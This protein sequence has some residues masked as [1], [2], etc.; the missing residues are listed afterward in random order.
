[1]KVGIIGGGMMGLA[2]AQRLSTRG[3][4]ITVFEREKQLGGLA[5]YHDF[6]QF[7]WDRFYHVI[8]PSDTYLINFMRDI[9][10]GDELR[11]KRTLTGFY[12]DQQFHSVS[13]TVE[14]LKFPLV[15]LV[16]KL[17]LALAILYCAR[18]N[19]WQRLE[20]VP[21]EGWL[22]KTCGRTT[23]EKMWKP[24]LLAKLG[25]NYRRVSAVFIW[26]Y[27]K[28]LYSARDSSASKEQMGHVSGGY[29]A[30]FERLEKSIA[31]AGGTIRT[32][33]S[34]ERIRA[35]AGGGLWVDHDQG[36]DRF[37]KVV[38]TSPVNVLEKV[39]QQGLV[40]LSN[41]G[42]GVEYLGVICMVLVTRKP[43]V[44]YYVVN[45]ADQRLPFT[46][47]IGM[48][49]VV[50]TDETAGFYLTYLPKYVLSD[51]P[52][53]REPDDKIRKLFF[54]GINLMFPDLKD[55]DIEG[56]YIN[57]A[58]KVQPLQVLNYSSLV[59]KVSTKHPDFFVLNTA[60]FV[61]TTL[62]NNEVIRAVEE[63]LNEYGH[64]FEDSNTQVEPVRAAAN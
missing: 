48:S 4:S 63:F 56:V 46:G 29:K 53:L 25:E 5:T 42:R 43:L 60:Q 26:S 30:V 44:P 54:A 2:L 47:A 45:I 16:G 52:L 64:R 62:N 9:G 10:L 19:D 3:H 59:P 14:F 27:I 11:W 7:F 1:M 18:I 38:F 55:D 41:T 35:A 51:D 15:S 61:N 24:L 12:V 6:G 13:S 21:L 49:N 50:S 33:I 31:D 32:E 39:A 8:L 34:V 37:D 17:R 22:I 23:Y 40:Q 28:R 20:Q 36:S 58:F 57:R